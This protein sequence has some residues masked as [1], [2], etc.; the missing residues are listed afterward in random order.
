MLA[1]FDDVVAGRDS[2]D[3]IHWSDEL[4]CAF[5]YAQKALSSTH[6]I[7]L[8]RPAD[9]LWIVTDGAV[10]ARP[11]GYI[12]HHVRF[13]VLI[14]HVAGAAILPSD[15]ASRNAPECES[16][17]CQV[18]TFIRTTA[19]SV[20]RQVTAEGV[21]R[22]AQ[23]LPFTNRSAW[24]ALQSECSDLRRTC[25]HLRQVV[26]STFAADVFR[27]DRQFILVVRECV[28]SF[29]LS[30]L[31]ED[32]RR[33]TLRDALLRLCLGLC[34]LDGPFAVIRTDPAPGFAA[35][36]GDEVLAKVVE[37]G[38]AKN[39]NKN[40]VAEKAVQELQGEI[41]RLEPNCRAVTPLLLSVATAR[42]NSRV[43]SRG[44]SAR[45]MLLQRDQFS[46]RQLPVNDQE[47]IMKQHSQRV[48]NHPYSVRSK[49]PSGRVAVPPTIRPGD[50]VYLYGDRNKSKARDRYLVTGVDGAWCNI[51]KFTG[52]QLRRTSY[53]VRLGDCYKVEGPLQTL[54]HSG[55]A[56]RLMWSRTTLSCVVLIYHRP[57][58]SP[59]GAMP[60]L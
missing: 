31:I 58:L 57:Y 60:A 34:P 54:I 33:E 39:I 28:T 18:C 9:Q 22:G 35:L 46:N 53:R 59:S 49:T 44:L 5:R 26:G 25:A 43:R 37:V 16:P 40:P 1:P 24:L 8:P 29:T 56:M 51:R 3:V 27:R 23:K 38:N 10:R 6:A 2:K 19:D 32:E 17:T 13:Q 7:T 52:T 41:L 14:R 47:L 48:T 36:A 12:I 55:I 50:L 45:E 15:F 4:L 30:S 20:V 42:L 11:R 21:M